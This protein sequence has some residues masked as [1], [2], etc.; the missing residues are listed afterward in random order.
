M[1]PLRAVTFD[2]DGL[3]F[4]SEDVYTDVGD[5][6]LGRRGRR[7][8]KDL[9]DAMMGLPPRPSFE[10]MIAWHGLSDTPESLIDESHALFVEL[11]DGKLQPM[12]GLTDLLD[13][14]ERHGIPKN[15]ATSSSHVV[16]DA[17][18]PQFTMKDR[19]DH[20]LASE[21]ILHGKPHPEI[22]LKSAERLG[23]EPGEMLVLEDSHNGCLAGA[24]AGAFVVAIPS[25]HSLD[26]DF[27]MARFVSTSLEDERIYRALGIPNKNG[28]REE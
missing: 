20:I 16:V 2:M 8:E 15:I 18:L 10:V 21:D 1:P 24:A 19:F 17:I 23:V 27:S 6:I 26:H 22:Y 14:L 28:N 7:F 25:E 9:K 11:M 5:A 3:M 12:P 13:A 4:N